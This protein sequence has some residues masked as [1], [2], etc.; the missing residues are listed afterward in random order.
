MSIIRRPSKE[1]GRVSLDWL[2]SRQTFSFAHYLDSAQMRF[3]RLRIINEDVVSPG[4]GF[5]THGHRD[6]EIVSYVIGGRLVHE[7]TAGNKCTLHRGDIQVL[8]AGTGIRHSECNGSACDELRF[9]QLWFLPCCNDL[10]VTYRQA[11]FDD[12]AKRDRLRLI[13]SPDGAAGS[14][15]INQD[16][17]LY[18][19]LLGAGKRLSYALA[20]GRG[21]W[22][23]VITG[24]LA[25]NGTSLLAGDGAAIENIPRLE[26][27]AVDPSEFLL[28]DLA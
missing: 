26:L 2:E 18:A 4:A 20:P 7:D 3:R 23:Q 10:A 11:H 8:S 5:G 14:L 6:M 1:R 19:S 12:G 13:V 25:V 17:R 27:T 22:L 28:I 16:A 24:S 9:L 15:V 21:A